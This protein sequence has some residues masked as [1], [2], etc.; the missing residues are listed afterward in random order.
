VPSPPLGLLQLVAAKDRR[1]EIG[2]GSWVSLTALCSISLVQLWLSF[3]PLRLGSGSGSAPSLLLWLGV[4]SRWLLLIYWFS[5]GFSLR[6]VFIT[7]SAK[8]RTIGYKN[9]FLLRC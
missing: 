2:L 6:L 4:R 8:N 9:C 7:S 1:R 5:V 3:A